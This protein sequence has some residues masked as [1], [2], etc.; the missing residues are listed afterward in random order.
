MKN[1]RTNIQKN[2]EFNILS[3]IHKYIARG[4]AGVHLQGTF[5][6]GG[7]IMVFF[8]ATFQVQGF[9]LPVGAVLETGVQ[10]PED[11]LRCGWRSVDIHKIPVP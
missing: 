4:I 2:K 9:F 6:K 5:G 7:M 10:P 1:L 3:Y 8:Y 11:F